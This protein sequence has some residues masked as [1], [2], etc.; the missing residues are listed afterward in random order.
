MSKVVSLFIALVS[1]AIV[2]GE[3]GSYGSYGSHGSYGS[4][5][6]DGEFIV[7]ENPT[8]TPTESPTTFPTVSPTAAPTAHPT[9]APTASTAAPTASPTVAPTAS[10][11]AAPTASPTPAPFEIVVVLGITFDNELTEDEEIIVCDSIESDVA[12]D[13]SIDATYVSCT[14][15]TV[16]AGA[17]RRLLAVE[18]ETTI[19][20]T[21]PS[22][23]T[24]D[25]V[26][27]VSTGVSDVDSISASVASIP[28]VVEANGGQEPV[29]FVESTIIDAQSGD[30]E[31]FTY[32]AA[33]TAPPTTAPP[34]TAPPTPAA[35]TPAPPTSEP[36]TAEPT[37]VPTAE[38]QT[39]SSSVR[40]TSSLFAA[41][42][43]VACVAVML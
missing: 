17:G 16:T 37:I 40:T 4:Y 43:S 32:T 36:T 24:D 35:P 10:P 34:T 20:I 26:E 14:M 33:P 5:G 9:V 11:T 6:S 41:L 21:L 23:I 18:Y 2:A 39:P 30:A 15:E 13:L 3:H 1:I 29:V 19:T 22:D 7:T 25:V 42:L 28:E 12:L 31:V 38:P 8:A 27:T